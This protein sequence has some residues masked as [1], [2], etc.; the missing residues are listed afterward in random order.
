[1]YLGTY[2]SLHCFCLIILTYSLSILWR[3]TFYVVI[4]AFP[5]HYQQNLQIHI[6]TNRQLAD[7]G[8]YQIGHLARRCLQNSPAHPQGNSGWD[9]ANIRIGPYAPF[10]FWLLASV[11]LTSIADQPIVPSV[12]AIRLHPRCAALTADSGSNGG[13]R[14]K[15]LAP[16]TT[17]SSLQPRKYCNGLLRLHPSSHA[18]KLTFTLLRLGNY[19]CRDSF[20]FCM[21]IS[22]SSR[23]TQRTNTYIHTQNRP[24]DT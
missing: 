6:A 21:A 4:T 22:P 19:I 5:P 16:R 12:P 3:R 15:A 8:I 1:M 7:V 17:M 13:K 24:S 20:L 18:P 2:V 9:R 11:F 23:P 10:Q 14:R